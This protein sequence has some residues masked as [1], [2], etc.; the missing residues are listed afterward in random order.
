MQ[1]VVLAGGLGQRMRP[2]TEALP[3]YLLEVAGRPFADHQLAWIASHGVAEVVLCIGHLG[4][5]IREHVGDG[6]SW[7]LRVSYVDEGRELMGTGGALRMAADA[8]LLRDE[9]GVL[10]GDSYLELALDAVFAD[11]QA[12]RPPAL[13]CTLRNEGR[14]DSSNASVA[15]GWVRRYEKGVDDPAAAGLD[16]IDYGFSIL[17]RELVEELVVPG[18]VVDLAAVY[19]L[20]AEQGRL[21]AFEASERFYEIGSASGLAELD[22]VLLRRA[23]PAAGRSA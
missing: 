17:R 13:M 7:G 22:R 2:A 5:R 20:L 4:E 3:K 6:S 11:F 1:V 16:Q 18:Q 12:R 23:G 9:F 14:W 8:G 21:A 10:Y 15:E 19:S